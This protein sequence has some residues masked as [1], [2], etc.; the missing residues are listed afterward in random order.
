MGWAVDFSLHLFD[1]IIYSIANI[2]TATFFLAIGLYFEACAHQFQII[3]TDINELADANSTIENRLKMKHSLIEA[4]HYHR[5]AKRYSVERDLDKRSLRLNKL[6]LPYSAFKSAHVL[7]SATI[8]F[9]V[10]V[11]VLFMSIVN[12]S[13]EIVRCT[14]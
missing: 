9:E 11:G 4:I 5:S 2:P 6:W 10:F 12:S 14:K 3:F 8:F 7:M 1:G 13:L